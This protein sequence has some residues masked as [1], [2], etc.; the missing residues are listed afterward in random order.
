V[1]DN[2]PGRERVAEASD[3][4]VDGSL[5]VIVRTWFKGEESLDFAP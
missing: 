4:R 3:F 2:F 5:Y 1:R